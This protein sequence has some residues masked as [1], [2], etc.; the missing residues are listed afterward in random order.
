MEE[1]SMLWQN[2][3]ALHVVLW[4]IGFSMGILFFFIISKHYAPSEAINDTYLHVVQ[5]IEILSQMR[6]NLLKSVEMEKNAVMAPT[7]EESR[8][9]ADESL[10]AS[11]AVEQDLKILL[12]LINASSLQNE[13]KLVKEFDTCWTEF[14]K[15]DQVILEFAVQNTNLKAAGLSREKG[16]ETIQRFVTVVEDVV[17]S[18]L[19][20][21][22]D[23]Q[24]AVAL[25]SLLATTAALQIFSLH[26]SHIAEISEEKMDQIEIQIKAKEKEVV[27]ALDDLAPI[28]DERTQEELL[29]AKEAFSKF[30]EVTSM[31]I[32]LSRQNSNIKSLELSLG[33][34]RVIAAQCQEILSALQKGVQ[35]RPF[36]AAK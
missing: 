20:T 22:N 15:L 10:A 28:V 14:G 29:Q 9:F 24:A 26:P 34:K 6:I 21:A 32:T 12:P 13:E 36:K 17:R 11:K 2:N 27:Q 5:K 8:Q 18:N 31:V 3:K 33:R 7:D 25:P 30:M 19:G 16:A 35:D 1:Q 4:A 23:H